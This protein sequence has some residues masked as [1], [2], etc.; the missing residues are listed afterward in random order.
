MHRVTCDIT[1]G[2][3]VGKLVYSVS[4]TWRAVLKFLHGVIS[5][6]NYYIDLARAKSEAPIN[7]FVI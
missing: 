5:V 3:P 2:P 6:N 4:P 7:K 1:L